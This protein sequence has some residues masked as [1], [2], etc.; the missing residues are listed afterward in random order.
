MFLE[1]KIAIF[2]EE[3]KVVTVKE[4]FRD[5]E[6]VLFLTWAVVM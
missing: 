1:V 2:G 5:I 4:D 6:N 3:D